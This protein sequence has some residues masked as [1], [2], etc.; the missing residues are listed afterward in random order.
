VRRWHA[1]SVASP[2]AASP[3]LVGGHLCAAGVEFDALALHVITAPS[4][5]LDHVPDCDALRET[6]ARLRRACWCSTPSPG[7]TVSTRTARARARDA[8]DDAPAPRAPRP[9]EHLL[10]VLDA[11][12]PLTRRAL[13]Q[14]SGRAGLRDFLRWLV[15]DAG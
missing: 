3:P 1:L 12:A 7:C 15:L 9:G 13:S 2:S 5:R 14:R 6:V 4:L 10:Q 11:G 8:V